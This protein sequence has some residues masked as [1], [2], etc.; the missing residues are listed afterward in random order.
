MIEVENLRAAS[1]YVCNQLLARGL[2]D[3]PIEFVS[4]E[5]DEVAVILR[6]INDLILRKDRDSENR[7]SLAT[8]IRT[9]RAENLRAID[10]VRRER[11]AHADT[12]RS[13]QSTEALV[14][15]LRSQLAHAEASVQKLKEEAVRTRSAV[16][17]T[18]A[19]CAKEVRKR[20]LQIDTLKKAV[21]DAGRARGER[22]AQAITTI[23]VTGDAC[24]TTGDAGRPGPGATT[25]DVYDL[26]LESSSFLAELAQGL[27]TEN[28]ELKTLIHK[29]QSMLQDMSGYQSGTTDSVQ[30]DVPLSCTAGV[31]EVG[32]EMDAILLHLRTILTNPS[33]VPIEEVVV[34][35]DEIHRLREGWEKM[36]SRWKDAMLLLETWRRRVGDGG[37]AVNV[38]EINMGLRLSPVR[39]RDAE[40]ASQDMAKRIPPLDLGLA[41]VREL[42]EEEEEYEEPQRRL[43]PSPSPAESLHLVPAPDFNDGVDDSDTDSESSIFVDENEEEDNV[44]VLEQS[45]MLDSS[46]LPVPPQLSPLKESASAGN[47]RNPDPS[48]SRKRPGDFTTILEE[49]SVD[50]EI[51]SKPPQPSKPRQSPI[52]AVAAR[53][54]PQERPDSAASC[55]SGTSTGTESSIRLVQPEAPPPNTSAPAK[56]AQP[57]PAKKRHTTR[58]AKEQKPP[59]KKPACPA[60]QPFS[61]R[62]TRASAAKSAPAP[63]QSRP[64]SPA[65]GAGFRP[66]H[67]ATKSTGSA[68]APAPTARAGRKA[69]TTPAKIVIPPVSSRLPLPRVANANGVPQSPLT[70]ATI[71]AK[72][73]A[74]ERDADAAR[75]RAKLKAARQ[76]RNGRAAAA[77]I[78]AEAA[79]A[80]SSRAA[81]NETARSAEDSENGSASIGS[82]GSSDSVKRE[83][84]AT[85]AASSARASPAVDQDA[86]SSTGPTVRMVVGELKSPRKRGRRA[87][88]VASRRR[89]TLNAWELNTLISGEVA[90]SPSK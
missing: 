40:P 54:V 27:S 21:G 16:A 78:A 24:A 51:L 36:E 73:A 80:P 60:A 41:P 57:P 86:G 88:R 43:P 47:R 71:A 79:S 58:A 62:P 32:A 76:G 22:K 87:E 66:G 85:S 39:V 49:D 44:V 53:Q 37:R 4:A 42:E 72:L 25:D 82:V 7:E 30:T 18:R 46:P 70:M 10:D 48:R 17:Q 9:L 69:V 31:E 6:V 89:S 3:C 13:L 19:A 81:S 52:T 29:V 35:E 12:R 77:A 50:M 75:V 38:Q 23:T 83:S 28:E 2:I 84:P 20:D 11:D 14:H 8:N 68:Q 64:E 1:T 65:E 45:I 15:T 61:S 55:T 26:R 59:A 56:P 90:V 63:A 5:P 33:F 67:K 74:S 34:R